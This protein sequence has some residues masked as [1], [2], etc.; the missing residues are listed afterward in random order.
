[1]STDQLKT[2]SE[3]IA[4]LARVRRQA[5]QAKKLKKHLKDFQA[6]F[7]ALEARC[8]EQTQALRQEC[9]LRDQTEEA[10]RLAEIIISRSPVVLFRRLAGEKPTLVYV[11]SNINQF[12]YSADDFLRGAIRFTQIVHPEDRDRLVKE[13]RA[14]AES[15]AEEYAQSYRIVTHSGEVR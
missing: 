10:L 1:M 3:L 8:D 13:I 4:E 6:E 7:G 11:S 9:S 5:V 14:F 12:G 15:D 2:K